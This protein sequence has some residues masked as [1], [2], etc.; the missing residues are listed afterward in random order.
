MRLAANKE[1][2]LLPFQ[3]I[4]RRINLA[5]QGG[6][7]GVCNFDHTRRFNIDASRPGSFDSLSIWQGLPDFG[8]QHLG[9]IRRCIFC[10]GGSWLLV[11]V[12]CLLVEDECVV[13]GTKFLGCLLKKE[14][15]FIAV[16]QE[17]SQQ[18]LSTIV[19]LE[20]TK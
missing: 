13:N 12:V 7:Q 18:R 6:A 15:K 19:E 10:H 14:W 20:R 5:L 17:S 8:K 1:N 4:L 16:N 11:A 3:A 9:G 2:Q